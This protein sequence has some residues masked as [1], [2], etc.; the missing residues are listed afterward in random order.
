[1]RKVNNL[2][3]ESVEQGNFVTAVYGVLD[4][5]NKIFTFTNAG[6]FPPFILRASNAVEFLGDGGLTLGIIPEKQYE[7]RPVQINSGDILVMYTDGVTDAEN[8]R[9]E[10][11]G[12]DRLVDLVK[13]NRE[14]SAEQIRMRVV[15]EVIKFNAAS[16]Q[17]DD[18]TLMIIKADYR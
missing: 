9:A 8:E 2:I 13:A 4:T 6:H 11:F 12:T 7:E 3:C 14:L 17:F 15:E 5:K 18:L 1:M 16:A 10:L